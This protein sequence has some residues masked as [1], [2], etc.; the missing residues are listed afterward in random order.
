[1]P[2]RVLLVQWS[3]YQVF[4]LI[5]SPAPTSDQCTSCIH[6][7]YL[8][9][10]TCIPCPVEC[11]GDCNGSDGSCLSCPEGLHL[12]N[13]L[14]ILFGWKHI[15]TS[16]LPNVSHVSTECSQTCDPISGYCPCEKGAIQKTQ[17]D[18]SLSAHAQLV[19]QWN[20]EHSLEPV[21][22]AQVAITCPMESVSSVRTIVSLVQAVINAPLASMAS[23]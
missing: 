11:G 22:H 1:M 6:G 21:N 16:R 4:G 20:V 12:V 5:V 3:L 14:C 17:T 23:I 2:K 9:N 8:N 19:V 18:G 13:G 10:S 7:K 15:G